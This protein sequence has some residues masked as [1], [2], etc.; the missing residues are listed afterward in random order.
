MIIKGLEHYDV[1]TVVIEKGKF[2][3][4]YQ[5]KEE[6]QN[7]LVKDTLQL[8]E[9]TPEEKRNRRKRE[10]RRKNKELRDKVNKIKNG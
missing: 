4:T 6:N 9:E 1:A 10:A 3:V 7:T 5:E 8:K 2:I